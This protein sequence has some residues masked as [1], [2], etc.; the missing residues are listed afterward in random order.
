MVGKSYQQS[1]K[2]HVLSVTKAWA[3]GQ[4]AVESYGLRDKSYGL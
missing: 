3:L 2:S 1:A 4:K